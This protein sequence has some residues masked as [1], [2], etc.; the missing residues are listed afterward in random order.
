MLYS[1]KSDEWHS[2]ITIV[3][4]TKLSSQKNQEETGKNG[5]ISKLG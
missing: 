3:T 1:S 4:A 2:G 5:W